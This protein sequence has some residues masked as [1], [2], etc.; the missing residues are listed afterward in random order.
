VTAA[1]FTNW[2]S[3]LNDAIPFLENGRVEQI[4]MAGSL[5]LVGDFYRHTHPL[6]VF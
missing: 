6:G 1:T 3:A 4:I 2:Q 5:Y